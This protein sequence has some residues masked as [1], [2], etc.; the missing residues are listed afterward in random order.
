MIVERLFLGVFWVP[1]D[2]GRGAF[3]NRA[4]QPAGHGIRV[5][6]GEFD[7]AALDFTDFTQNGSFC[8][9][10]LFLREGTFFEM[11]LELKEL[12]LRQLGLPVARV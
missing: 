4:S 8:L 12:L 1:G 5:T 11:D 2:G 10:V 3:A 7:L 9:K 6:A